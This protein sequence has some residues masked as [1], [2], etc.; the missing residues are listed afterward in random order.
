MYFSDFID[1][2]SEQFGNFVQSFG[3]NCDII[4]YKCRGRMIK[5]FAISIFVSFFLIFDTFTPEKCKKYS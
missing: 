5:M 4:F 2:Y 1:R 3:K